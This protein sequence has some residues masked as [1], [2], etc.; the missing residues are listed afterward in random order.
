MKLLDHADLAALGIKFSR[1]HLWRLCRA[2]RFP[3]PIKLSPGR[4]AWSEAEIADW[5]KAR[6][7]ERDGGR[8]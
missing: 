6:I 8:Q 1:V 3:K 5:I 4:N 7:A 2:G